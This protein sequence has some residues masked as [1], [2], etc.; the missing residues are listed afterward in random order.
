MDVGTLFSG[1]KDSSYALYLASK[2]YDVKCLICLNP[3][4]DDS[5]MFH[6]P[7]IK[8]V[9]EQAENMDIPL[10][11]MTSSGEK[12]EELK[13]LKNAI[14]VA[15]Q[16]YKIQGI[17]SGAL[18]SNYQKERV[19]KICSEL[20]LESIVPLWQIDAGHYMRRL[21]LSGFKVIITGIA[22]DGFDDKWLGREL[23]RNVLEELEKLSKE[24]GMNLCGEGGEYET[25]VLD[26][27]LFKRKLKV[28]EAEKK[29]ENSNTGK[30]IIKN[31]EFENK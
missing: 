14:E 19:D 4:K 28:I 7:N 26:C 13:D 21:L 17:V 16:K 6:F 2:K 27:P 29:L 31:I 9:K 15:K 18:Y 5:W 23:N 20:K 30:Y 1:G 11:F 22:A 12:E 8:F 10:I 3:E 25:F 24:K